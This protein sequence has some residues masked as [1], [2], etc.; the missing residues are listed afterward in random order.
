MLGN[1]RNG[2][3]AAIGRRLQ[4]EEADRFA[5]DLL[6]IIEGF[7]RSGVMTLSGIHRAPRL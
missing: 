2:R 6:P 5:A 1:H 7:R 3:E 4:T